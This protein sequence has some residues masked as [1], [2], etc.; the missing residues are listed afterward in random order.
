MKNS[1]Y[2][3]K[4][5]IF[6]VV[7]MALLALAVS[8]TAEECAPGTHNLVEVITVKPTCNSEGKAITRCTVCG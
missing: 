5:L 3:R 8:A 1:S 7:V 6:A 2:I 4:I